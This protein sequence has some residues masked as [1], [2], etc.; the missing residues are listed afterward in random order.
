[1]P[2]YL[3]ISN[4]KLVFLYKVSSVKTFVTILKLIYLGGITNALILYSSLFLKFPNF[5]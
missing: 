3:G 4:F 1:M 5:S 2:V